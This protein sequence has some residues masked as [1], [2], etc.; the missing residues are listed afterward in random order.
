MQRLI[1]TIYRALLHV[2]HT[3]Q[4]LEQRGF[5]RPVDPSKNTSS[6]GRSVNEQSA[7]TG[8]VPYA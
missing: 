4:Q 7:S 6:P 5:S 3:G 2:Q 8:A 1:A